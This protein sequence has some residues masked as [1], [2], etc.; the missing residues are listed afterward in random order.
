MTNPGEDASAKP[1][2]DTGS[3]TEPSAAGY[4]A[5]P[6]EQAPEAPQPSAPNADFPPPSGYESPAY[7]GY[8][9]PS[10]P[11]P[12]FAPPDY[13][14]AAYPPPPPGY[15]PPGPQAPAEY[16]PFG[17][18]PPDYSASGYP[19]PPNYGAPQFGAPPPGYPAPPPY[20]AAPQFPAPGYGPGYGMPPARQTNPMA[21]ASIV[22]SGL[23]IPLFFMCLILGPPAAIAGIVFGIVAL[24]Q[25]KRSGQGG[26][27]LAIA[28]IAVGGLVLVLGV[29]LA[30]VVGAAMSI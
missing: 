12:G 11:Q 9:A 30:I 13:S 10:Y 23:A 1:P 4:E 21:T 27:E 17:S 25:I 2:A 15:G 22:S 16:P 3:G 20:G 14:S 6:I 18:V 8:Q 26:K 29:I 7:G 24:G 5:A 28:G 19:P